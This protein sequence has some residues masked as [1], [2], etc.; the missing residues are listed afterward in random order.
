MNVVLLV[1]KKEEPPDVIP[2][3]EFYWLPRDLTSLPIAVVMKDGRWVWLLLLLWLQ[4]TAI[5]TERLIPMSTSQFGVE[6]SYC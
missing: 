3:A 5:F 1:I 4:T 2:M 6:A